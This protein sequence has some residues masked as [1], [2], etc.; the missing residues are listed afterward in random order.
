MPAYGDRSVFAAQ[1]LLRKTGGYDTYNG[2]TL[3]LVETQNVTLSLP[4]DLLRKLKIYAAEQDTSMSALLTSM[5]RDLLA[6]R[7][8]YEK[9]WRRST[10]RLKEGFDMG[11]KGSR[12]WTR[13]ELHDR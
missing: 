10:A 3:F 1:F 9:A 5:L 8:E 12:H 2:A 4:R 11:I 6:S 13:D 7:D